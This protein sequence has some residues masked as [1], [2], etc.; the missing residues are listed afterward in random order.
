MDRS[1]RMQVTPHEVNL[2]H[3]EMT[4]GMI[5]VFVQKRVKFP[6]ADPR[7]AS[8]SEGQVRSEWPRIQRDTQGCQGRF[9]TAMEL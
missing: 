1:F 6:A 2:G 7:C 3:D 4:E 9:D 5:P 8:T